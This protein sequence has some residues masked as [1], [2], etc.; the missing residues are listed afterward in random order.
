MHGGDDCRMRQVARPRRIQPHFA[1]HVRRPFREHQHAVGELREQNAVIL[2]K[3]EENE[4]L[5]LNG[6][7]APIANRLRHGDQ[8]IADGFADIQMGSLKVRQPVEALERLGRARVQQQERAVFRP[9]A[10]EFVPIEFDIRGHR[11]AEERNH[12]LRRR[13]RLA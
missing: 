10:P 4:Q 12:P 13:R 6:L 5:L 11:A 3:N 2:A 1:A 8:G 9:V 7:P